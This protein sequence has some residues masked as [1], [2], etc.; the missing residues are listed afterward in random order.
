M[1]TLDTLRL[2]A[3][4]FRL[5]RL[6]RETCSLAEVLDFQARVDQ[7]AG[8]FGVD[9]AAL[10]K[11]IRATAPLRIETSFTIA[12]M[13]VLGSRPPKPSRE[14]RNASYWIHF[15]YRD[16][17]K[18]DAVI[19]DLDELLCERLKQDGEKK[20]LRWYRAEVAWLL[21][22]LLLALLRRMVSAAARTLSR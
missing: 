8:K 11:H 3:E 10:W 1:R 14:Q 6:A 17:K 13:L 15:F 18:A 2:S 22:N 16:Q 19:G 20:A 21:I 5:A 4:L 12:T 7:T 9:S